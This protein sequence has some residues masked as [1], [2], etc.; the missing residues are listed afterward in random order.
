[1]R[2]RPI[3]I[4]HIKKDAK[5]LDGIYFLNDNAFLSLIMEDNEVKCRTLSEFASTYNPPVF[6]RQF[7]KNTERAVS[8]FQSSDVPNQTERSEVFINKKQAVKLNTIVKKNQILITGFGTIG[9]TRLVSKLQDGVAYANNVCRVDV[10]D[11]QKYGFIY[12]FISSKYGRGQLNKNASGSV[13]RYIEAPGIRKILI[14][15][16]SPEKQEEIHSLIVQAAELR[17]KANQLLEKSVTIFENNM[18]QINSNTQFVVSVK[19]LFDNT[20]RLDSSTNFSNIQGF[21]ECLKNNCELKTIEEL[22]K[23]VFTPGIFKRIRVNNSKSG[24]PFLSGSD[25]LDSMPSFNSFLSKKMKNL[26]DYIL[27]KGWIAVQDAGTIGYVTLVSGYLDGVSATNNL[28]RI[29]PQTEKNNNP[30]IFAFLKT[31]QGQA[32]L[33]S[34]EYGSVQKHIDNNQVSRIKIPILPM[35]TEISTNILSYLDKLTEACNK[36]FQAIQLVETEIDQWQQ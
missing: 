30:Y 1:M 15:V 36:E 16:F 35:Y 4:K 14:P 28:V 17:E 3:N 24:I 20:L 8:Y 13:V 5:R 18:P 33:K 6:K 22:S 2:S 23:K 31:K 25:L 7:C 32:I 27:R 21:Y 11:D 29:I 10:N 19:S 12:A 34:L 26:D 9:N